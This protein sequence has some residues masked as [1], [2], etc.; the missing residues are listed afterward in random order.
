MSYPVDV[1]RLVTH[2]AVIV[3]AGIEPADI[4][5]HYNENIRFVGNCRLCK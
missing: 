4:I 2:H 5:P 3:N 1:G